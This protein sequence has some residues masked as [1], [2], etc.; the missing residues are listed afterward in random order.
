MLIPVR[1]HSYKDFP[2]TDI[3]SRCVRFQ[4][5]TIFQ[6]HPFSFAPDYPYQ[7]GLFFSRFFRMFLLPGHVS[8]SFRSDRGQVAQIRYSFEGNQPGYCRRL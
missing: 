4:Y 6:A 1:W 3:N 5:G 7:L 8:R 2:R